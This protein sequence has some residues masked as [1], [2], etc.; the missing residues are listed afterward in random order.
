MHLEVLDKDQ[1]TSDDFIGSVTVKM[2]EKND[3]RFLRLSIFSTFPLLWI[4]AGFIS[5][6]QLS[7]DV[8]Q[9]GEYVPAIDFNEFSAESALLGSTKSTNEVVVKHLN[10]AAVSEVMSWMLNAYY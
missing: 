9:K 5:K 6:T 3:V 8:L 1:M 10:K 7:N 4:S 2:G